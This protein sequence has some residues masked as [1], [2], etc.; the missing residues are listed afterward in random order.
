IGS[1]TQ[2]KTRLIIGSHSLDSDAASGVRQKNNA[3]TGGTQRALPPSTSSTT[4]GVIELLITTDCL[5][6]FKQFIRRWSFAI[7]V[8]LP[9]TI[10]PKR[11]IV[12]SV[13]DLNETT[14][15]PFRCRQCNFFQD[16][17]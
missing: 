1:S 9:G 8:Q 17:L 16:L 5:V 7:L 6:P 11:A 15:K 14:Q 3:G 12:L 2:P 10:P 13:R 4:P